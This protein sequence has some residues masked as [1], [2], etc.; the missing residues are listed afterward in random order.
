M[1]RQEIISNGQVYNNKL[2]K[3]L[4][5]LTLLFQVLINKT[6]AEGPIKELLMISHN[7]FYDY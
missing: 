4:D 6:N 2:A 7:W 3:I 5:G 1:E